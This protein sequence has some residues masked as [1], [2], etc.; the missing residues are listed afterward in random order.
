MSF[1]KYQACTCAYESSRV[2]WLGDALMLLARM[3]HSCWTVSPFTLTRSAAATA[4][5][6]TSTHTRVRLAAQLELALASSPAASLTAALRL[7]APLQVVVAITS[8]AIKSPMVVKPSSLHN[9]AGRQKQ[10]V[11][12]VSEGDEKV[13]TTTS[14]TYQWH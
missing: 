12:A 1:H 9:V 4:P 7:P 10:T 3:F 8:Y 11:D 5:T 13:R 6:Q 14:I 2:H